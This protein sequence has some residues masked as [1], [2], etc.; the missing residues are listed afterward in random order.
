VKNLAKYPTTPFEIRQDDCCVFVSAGLDYF[1][2]SRKTTSKA[3][4]MFFP[5]CHT[6]TI[7]RQRNGLAWCFGLAIVLGLGGWASRAEASCGDYLA[8][9][10]GHFAMPGES[11]TG[12][13]PNPT[14]AE[15]P[16]PSTPAHPP[17]NGPSCSSREIPVNSM[18][19]VVRVQ[20]DLTGAC[21]GHDD[22]GFAS[23]PRWPSPSQESLA[24]LDFVFRILRPPRPLSL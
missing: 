19:D 10:S 16:V 20:H 8:V 23:P 22:G 24:G 17:C 9:G 12:Q 1:F 3:R 6:S 18:H 14:H 7:L 21:L 15:I 11:E 4:S 2:P 13:S 5:L